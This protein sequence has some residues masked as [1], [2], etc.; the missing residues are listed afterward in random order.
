MCG[1]LVAM[2]NPKQLDYRDEIIARWGEPAYDRTQQWWQG[3]TEVGQAAFLAESQ[4]LAQDWLACCAQ[5]LP[6]ASPPAQALAR[7]HYAWITAGWGGVAPTGTQLAGLAQMYPEDPR[8]AAN[9]GGPDGA[10]YVRDAL[11]VLA[12][13]ISDE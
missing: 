3:L 6:P 5:D 10:R 13:Q 2:T 9:Y 1:R 7:R 4:S 8:F 12:A 11:L